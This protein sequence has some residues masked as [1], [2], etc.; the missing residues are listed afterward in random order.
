MD[1]GTA[2]DAR[3]EEAAGADSPEWG[4]R[5]TSWWATLPVYSSVE[6]SSMTT[7]KFF[8]ATT[9]ECFHQRKRASSIS[10]VFHEVKLEVTTISMTGSDPLLV[11]DLPGHFFVRLM[12]GPL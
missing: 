7:L 10:R 3:G 6:Y 12:E 11:P 4:G 8:S 2:G 1:P 5:T 9:G